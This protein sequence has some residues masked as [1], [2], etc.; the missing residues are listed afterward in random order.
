V[1]RLL[2]ISDDGRSRAALR[3]MLQ[4]HGIDTS[5]FSHARV[6]IPEGPL[7]AAVADSTSY[8]EVMRALALPV[9]DSNH[10]RVHRQTARLGLDTTHFKRSARRVV[11]PRAPKPVADDLLRVLPNGSPRINH[12]RLRAALDEIGVPYECA[13]CGNPGE[14]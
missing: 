14:W 2:G 12:T 7:R 5:H 11:R 9:N 1:A 10:R 8:A 4:E 6:T 3:R 13:R